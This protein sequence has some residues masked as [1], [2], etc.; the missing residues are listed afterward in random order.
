MSRDVADTVVIWAYAS[1]TEGQVPLAAP[2]ITAS[3]D[4]R[5]SSVTIE[6]SL[7]RREALT[8]LQTHLSF[9]S[10]P[11]N[12]CAGI[13]AYAAHLVGTLPRG[14]IEESRTVLLGLLVEHL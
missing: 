14:N 5:R 7:A 6:P 11:K 4:G 2:Y 8:Y 3:P 13:I 9:P 10:A 1:T 12:Q